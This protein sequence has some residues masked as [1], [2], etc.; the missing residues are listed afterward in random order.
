MSL[1]PAEHWRVL[2]LLLLYG[3]VLF[4]NGRAGR[5]RSSSV[6]EYYVG[7]RRFGGIAL[8]ISFYATYAST[9]SFIGNAGKSWS[10]GLPWL[11]NLAFMLLFCALSWWWIAPRLRQATA[12]HAALTLPEWFGRRFADDRVR[13]LAALI[14]VFAS[15]LYMTAV[16]KGVGNLLEVFLAV[17]YGAVIVLVLLVVVFYT[18]A[19][20]FH[21]VVR[22]DVFQG[23]LLAAGSVVLF[24]G[25]T[26]AAGGVASIL[27]V[28]TRPGAEGLFDLDAAMPFPVLLGILFAGSVKLLVEPRQLSRFFA[29]R[30]TSAT[31]QG[32]VVAV[33][34]VLL[35]LG[36]LLPIGLYARMILPAEAIGDT[37]LVVPTLLA[38][39]IFPPW[40]AALLV[41]AMVAAAMSSLDSVLLVAASTLDRDVLALRVGDGDARAVRRTRGLVIGLCALTAMLAW[42]PPAGIVELTIWSG[43]LYAA[44]FL[45]T[46][47]GGL[48]LGRGDGVTALV[49]ML[50]GLA[51]L[52]AWRFT[53]GDRVVHEVFP[54]LATST[55][56]FLLCARVRPPANDAAIAGRA[57]V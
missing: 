51:V 15:L 28:P 16:F 41:L 20:G 57:D 9:N 13:R 54:A 34:G 48:F 42:R 50:G 52:L 43:S 35:V 18:A 37:D 33:L 4:V 49:A 56:L 19:G 46:L 29:L 55:V 45:P 44:C 3:A 1:W 17:P 8:G 23:L 31:R 22:T 53:S 47:L 38:M 32:L 14:V 7:G 36:L 27:D 26:G 30:D 21:S 11:L 6:S 25:V 24:L 2:L 10:Y 12:A 40:I 5:A 39:D